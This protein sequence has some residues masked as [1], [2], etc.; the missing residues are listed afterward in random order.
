MKKLLLILL[1]TISINTYAKDYVVISV[2]VSLS[3]YS[4]TVIM[5]TVVG[6][7]GGGLI[8]ENTMMRSE[9]NIT[10]GRGCLY[11]WGGKL[12]KRK[13]LVSPLLGIGESH[14]NKRYFQYGVKASYKLSF[15]NLGVMYN[16]T[17]KLSFIVGFFIGYK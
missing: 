6:D 3:T 4:H 12:I 9:M 14:H 1:L 7:I 15:L 5:G 17:S 8:G 2:P 11:V 16:T 13:Y 10:N